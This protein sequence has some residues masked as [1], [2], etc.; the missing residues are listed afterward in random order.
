MQTEKLQVKQQSLS[1]E[2]AATYYMTLMKHSSDKRISAERESVESRKPA[3][4][5]LRE[6]RFSPVSWKLII[7][8]GNVVYTLLQ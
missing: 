7:T 3:E 2:I 4:E 6:R 5:V 8:L 1:V